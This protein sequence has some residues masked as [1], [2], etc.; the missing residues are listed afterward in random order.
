MIAIR[1]RGPTPPVEPPTRR[2]QQDDRLRRRKMHP[3]RGMGRPNPTAITHCGRA[4]LEGSRR[5]ARRPNTSS[6]PSLREDPSHLCLASK[7]SIDCWPRHA[8]ATRRARRQIH[9]RRRI[10]TCNNDVFQRVL[11][12]SRCRRE[13]R[14]RQ[15]A[16]KRRRSRTV[17]GKRRQQRRPKTR[18][19]T[20]PDETLTSDNNNLDG[21]TSLGSGMN[22][23]TTKV[24]R[25][26]TPKPPPSA[27]PSDRSKS[28][29]W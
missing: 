28:R 29:R 1:S 2:R 13:E 27:S 12:S 8:R 25:P 5:P 18:P 14:P 6:R 21:R 3:P 15:V 20:M 19:A 7:N 26:P 4:R 23:Y 10:T 16:A 11:E 24:T 9:R 22:T 17:K